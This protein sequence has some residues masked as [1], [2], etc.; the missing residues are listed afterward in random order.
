MVIVDNATYSYGFQLCNGVPILPWYEDMSDK[1]L[2]HLMSYLRFLANRQDIRAINE[3]VF[4]YLELK[5]HCENTSI[6]F[7]KLITSAE[8]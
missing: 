2:L 8:T 7:Y 5:N 4:K 6:D 1:E 3:K